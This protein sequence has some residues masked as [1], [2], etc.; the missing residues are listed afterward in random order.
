MFPAR[1]TLKSPLGKSERVIST[2]DSTGL[3]KLGIFIG[4]VTERLR[5]D[6]LSSVSRN[7]SPS[8][9][10]LSAKMGI[11][12][13]EIKLTQYVHNNDVGFKF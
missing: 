12:I 8:S 6:R 9:G 4:F 11:Y 5:R 3:P 2:L 13:Q 1:D 10:M 7:I